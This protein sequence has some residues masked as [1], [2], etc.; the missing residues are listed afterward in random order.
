MGVRSP[1]SRVT[2]NAVAVGLGRQGEGME[3][4]KE[5]LAVLGNR[6]EELREFVVGTVE[7][8]LEKLKGGYGDEIEI[9][10]MKEIYN[11]DITIWIQDSALGATTDAMYPVAEGAIEIAYRD[12]VHYDAVVLLTRP[13]V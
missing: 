8:Y 13:R 3:V 7:D 10:F 11:T 2:A 1:R 4:H 9:R 12:G 5:V 6:K